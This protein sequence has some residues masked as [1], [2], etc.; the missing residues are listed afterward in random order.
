MSEY[1][2]NHIIKLR[3][4]LLNLARKNSSPTRTIA[5]VWKTSNTPRDL[6]HNIVSHRIQSRGENHQ[7]LRASTDPTVIDDYQETIWKFFGQMQEFDDVCNKIDGEFDEIFEI[8]FEWTMREVLENALEFLLAKGVIEAIPTQVAVD[9]AVEKVGDYRISDKIREVADAKKSVSKKVLPPRYYGIAVEVDLKKHLTPYFTEGQ[10]Q[11]W[12]E[13]HVVDVL[14]KVDRVESAPH[15][16]LVHEKEVESCAVDDMTA[17]SATNLWTLY[18]TLS[19]SED[20]NSVEIV[21]GPLLAYDS[22]VMAVQVSSITSLA[23]PP[24]S[25]ELVAGKKA[26]VTIGTLRHE[27]R[28]IEGKFIIE[29]ALAGEASTEAGGVIMTKEIG[30]ITCRGKIAGLR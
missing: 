18:S 26:H 6:L 13:L 5:F 22:R 21:L 7:N 27:I 12:E 24:R 15:I 30:L 10:N 4:D 8:D 17:S 9:A 3:E 14:K 19:T 23:T 29:Q 2:N 1:R 11:L 28:P 25:I 16:T 20:S